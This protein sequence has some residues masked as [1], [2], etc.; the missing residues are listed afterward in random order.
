MKLHLFKI[1]S[2]IVFILLQL[3][4]VSPTW[5][6]MY[7]KSFPICSGSL[8][9]FSPGKFGQGLAII[10]F[11][12]GLQYCFP[13]NA[14]PEAATIEFWFVP[15]RNINKYD[16][17]KTLLHIVRRANI[18]ELFSESALE[19]LYTKN[20]IKLIADD[21]KVLFSFPLKKSML[22]KGVPSHFAL[23]WENSQI[24]LYIDGKTFS[25]VSYDFKQKN[26]SFSI[27]FGT[28][29]FHNLKFAPGIYDALHISTNRISATD[30][31]KNVYSEKSPEMIPKTFLLANFENTTNAIVSFSN[32]NKDKLRKFQVETFDCNKIFFDN[33]N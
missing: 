10:D 17:P 29:A 26:C 22:Q 8:P 32:I 24:A 28:N 20:S 15:N 33:E 19:L 18:K 11:C 9:K 31:K 27:F 21:T 3:V 7:L 4:K 12:D 1:I 6:D 23:S 5:G 2:I 25:D 16:S 30:L 13:E 14:L